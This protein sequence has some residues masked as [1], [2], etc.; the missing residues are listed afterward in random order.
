M[1]RLEPRRVHST[2]AG[3]VAKTLHHAFV[4]VS[5]PRLESVTACRRFFSMTRLPVTACLGFGRM[6][7][8]AEAAYEPSEPAR[9]WDR[10]SDKGRLLA[11]YSDQY[12]VSSGQV[13][14]PHASIV[15]VELT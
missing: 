13:P 14:G 6:A 10:P 1:P 7:A 5:F 2:E 3:S 9:P 4:N 8:T 12:R 15:V 11:F